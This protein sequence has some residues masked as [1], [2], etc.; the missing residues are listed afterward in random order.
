MI[1]ELLFHEFSSVK[2]QVYEENF[3]LKLQRLKQ[4]NWRRQQQVAKI[5]LVEV[6]S[7]AI[8]ARPQCHCSRWPVRTTHFS[9][10]AAAVAI[11][12]A[13]HRD[14][15]SFGVELALSAEQQASWCWLRSHC[16]LCSPVKRQKVTGSCVCTRLWRRNERQGNA[17]CATTWRQ[18]KEQA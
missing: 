14:T 13:A 4:S 16:C 18:R 11:A 2:F 6:N 1:V 15:S 3:A 10:A 17:K 12:I 5:Q 8:I 9:D 7:S